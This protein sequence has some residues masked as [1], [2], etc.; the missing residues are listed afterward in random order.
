MSRKKKN[1][2]LRGAKKRHRQ[3]RVDNN[4][5]TPDMMWVLI[6][7]TRGHMEVASTPD[8]NNYC[9]HTSLIGKPSRELLVQKATVEALLSRR[10]LRP[11]PIFPAMLQCTEQGRTTTYRKILASGGSAKWDGGYQNR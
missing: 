7:V 2:R 6:G 8:G 9:A 10:L 1:R 5:L 4:G 11:D 3:F